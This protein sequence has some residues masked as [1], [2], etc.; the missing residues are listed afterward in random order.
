M[1]VWK[2]VVGL[3]SHYEVSSRGGGRVRSLDRVLPIGKGSFKRL[4]KG[5]ILK[6]TDKGNGY[7]VVNLGRGNRA[8]VHRLVAEAFLPN[9]DNLPC[10]N[11]KDE[12]PHN[13]ELDNLEWCTHKYNV[14][15]GT[16]IERMTKKLCKPVRA[17]NLN[18]GEVL[19]FSSIKTA[20]Q[21]GFD[22]ST[23][24]KCCK[25]IYHQHNGYEWEYIKEDI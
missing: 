24:I 15:Y 25:G 1:E 3:E 20:N 4:H 12:N 21:A 19:E 14:N 17:T 6:L 18:S 10:V 22:S 7:L 11:H 23:I 9:E 2:P 13:N 8:H 16:A 5:K